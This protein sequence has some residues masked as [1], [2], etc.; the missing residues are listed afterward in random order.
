MSCLGSEKWKTL[1][2]ADLSMLHLKKDRA[3]TLVHKNRLII[4]V[5]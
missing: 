4:L 1:E 5:I 3:W 2:M